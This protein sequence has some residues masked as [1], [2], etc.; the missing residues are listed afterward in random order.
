M[1]TA[2]N[3]FGPVWLVAA[4]FAVTAFLPSVCAQ[5][6]SPANAVQPVV[7][8]LDPTRQLKIIRSSDGKIVDARRD[9]ILAS[10]DRLETGRDG[11]ATLDWYGLGVMTV[12]PIAKITI[13]PPAATKKRAGFNLFQGLIYFF[14]RDQPREF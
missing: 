6:H 14:H 13:T 5:T 7:R 9:M 4:V 11:R 2:C 3:R 8:I 10:G 1:R 12:G